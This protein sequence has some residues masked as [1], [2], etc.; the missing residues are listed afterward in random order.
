M[1]HVVM[2][3]YPSCVYKNVGNTATPNDI[4]RIQSPPEKGGAVVL[5]LGQ[6]CRVGIDLST[7]TSQIG[8][9][10]TLLRS[11]GAVSV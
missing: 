10:E 11:T 3:H 7:N 1:A 9:M 4:L 6:S 2:I 8:R 5:L